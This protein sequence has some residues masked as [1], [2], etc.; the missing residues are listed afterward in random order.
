MDTIA[1]KINAKFML[2]LGDNFY[3]AGVKSDTD[4]R[5][6]ITFEDVYTPQSLQFEWY[7]VAGN[8]GKPILHFF[9]RE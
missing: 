2:A 9:S 3:S 1:Q 6:D 8:H 7:V 4:T 5:F